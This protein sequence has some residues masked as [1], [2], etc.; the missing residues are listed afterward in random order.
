MAYYN[1][2]SA[3]PNCFAVGL[4]DHAVPGTLDGSFP[5]AEEKKLNVAMNTARLFP[6]EFIQSSLGNRVYGFSW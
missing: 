1:Y 3:T 6:D 2:V 4:C 5:N